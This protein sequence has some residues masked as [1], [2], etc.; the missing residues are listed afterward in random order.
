MM[1]LLP[2]FLLLFI[3]LFLF[4]HLFS[5]RV[6]VCVRDAEKAPSEPEP[7]GVGYQVERKTHTHT[8]RDAQYYTTQVTYTEEN[9]NSLLPLLTAF[10]TSHTLRA[11]RFEI[12]IWRHCGRPTFGSNCFSFSGY[13]LGTL[14]ASVNH[15]RT[16]TTA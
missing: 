14:C 1:I 16:G 2:P 3:G 15:A 5:D 13:A 4:F 11:E 9:E 6:A 7:C 8:Q 12:I 10:A